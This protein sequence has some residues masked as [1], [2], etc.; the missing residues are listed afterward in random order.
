MH[1]LLVNYEI[2]CCFILISFFISMLKV[3]FVYSDFYII[4][5]ALFLNQT[6]EN[7]LVVTK[8]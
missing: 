3:I 5:E 2:Y 8:I 4:A 6:I 7:S 1:L